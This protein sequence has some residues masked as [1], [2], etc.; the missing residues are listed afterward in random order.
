M[1]MER[2][3][4]PTVFTIHITAYHYHARIIQSYA[5]VIKLPFIYLRSHRIHRLQDIRCLWC[6]SRFHLQ[7]IVGIVNK[8]KRIGQRVFHRRRF[9]NLNPG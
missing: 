4:D 9:V 6:L 8:A 2:E 3:V 7:G 5:K 1:I